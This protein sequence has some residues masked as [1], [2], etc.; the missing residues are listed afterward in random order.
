M[1][2]RCK[3]RVFLVFVT[4]FTFFNV[5]FYFANVFYFVFIFFCLTHI[6]LQDRAQ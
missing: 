4:F 2:H 6:D 1:I 5:F 3:K